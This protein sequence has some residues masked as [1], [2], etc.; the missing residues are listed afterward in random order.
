[1]K[2]DMTYEDIRGRVRES[3]LERIDY[4]RET[5]DDQILEMIDEEIV[6]AGREYPFSLEERKRMR[7]ELFHSIRRLDVLQELLEDTGITEILS[8]IH[9]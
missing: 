2:R 6:R 3:I 8:L 9:I 1:M 7:Q 5:G 4:S